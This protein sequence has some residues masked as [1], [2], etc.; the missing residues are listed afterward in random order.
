MEAIT[1]TMNIPVRI[2]PF[3]FGRES[4]MKAIVVI[5]HLLSLHR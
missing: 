1:A 2:V 5:Y 4:L 3:S